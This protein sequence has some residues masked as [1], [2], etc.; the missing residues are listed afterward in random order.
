MQ[1]NPGLKRAIIEL[2]ESSGGKLADEKGGL[3]DAIYKQLPNAPWKPAPVNKNVVRV[4]LEQLADQGRIKLDRR[5]RK[6]YAMAHMRR[7]EGPGNVI[8]TPSEV[9]PDVAFEAELIP[10]E[11]EA[12]EM[13]ELDLTAE[14]VVKLVAQVGPMDC[15]RELLRLVVQVART[16]IPDPTELED[17]RKKCTDLAQESQRFRRLLNQLKQE[18]ST[19]DANVRRL[20]SDLEQAQ[21]DNKE[22]TELYEL[23]DTE[24]A[25]LKQKL[26]EMTRIAAVYEDNFVRDLVDAAETMP[27]GTGV[28][29]DILGRAKKAAAD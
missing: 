4:A 21:R 10:E 9:D 19:A 7:H 25:E 18:K 14:N 8:A 27:H 1:V 6:L 12:V 23:A 2:L 17:L 24:R 3:V 28:L 22:L 11:S 20:S 5:G 16:P 29:D 15:A 26:G 13:A